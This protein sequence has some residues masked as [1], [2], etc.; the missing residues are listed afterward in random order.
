[1]FFTIRIGL[2]DI[3]ATVVA[4][5]IAKIKPK[6]AINL[7]IDTIFFAIEHHQFAVFINSDTIFPGIAVY[8]T[9]PRD[10]CVMS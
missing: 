3:F 4:I 8:C 6:I 2:L 7:I 9:Q 1:M 10:G 5:G